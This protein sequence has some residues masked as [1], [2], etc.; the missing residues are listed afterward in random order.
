V[1]ACGGGY[2]KPNDQLIASQASLTSAQAVG[3]TA[4]PQAQLYVKLAQ[5]E[6]QRAKAE[7]DNGD[8]E[9]AAYSL[10]RAKAD[11]DLAIELTRAINA[12]AR[13]QQVQEHMKQP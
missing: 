9:R 5:E 2:P 13:E 1:G 6:I 10:L 7:M 12:R 4:D 11:A 3:A 8:N